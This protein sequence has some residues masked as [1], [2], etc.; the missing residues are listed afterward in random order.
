MTYRLE[1]LMQLNLRTYLICLLTF[2]FAFA[3]IGCSDENPSGV[4]SD[5]T[6]NILRGKVLNVDINNSTV[7]VE[8]LA[9]SHNL[10]DKI[11]GRIGSKISLQVQ[12]GDLSLLSNKKVFVGNLQETFSSTAGK[13]FLLYDVW[14]DEKAERIRVKNV[15]RLLRR[16]TLGMGEAMLRTVGD[17]LPPF[18][19]YDQDG[20]VVT[21]DYFDGSVTVLNFIFS[22]C[23]VAEMC[24]A[25]TIKMKK[26]QELAH[27]IKIPNIRFLSIT[28]DP[29]F[30]SP[31]VLK[32]YARGYN[33]EESNFKVCT[34][35]KPVIDDLTR[36]FGIF[37]E[38]AP[39]Q[40]L[41]HTMRTMI[42]NSKRQIVYQVPGKSWRVEDFLSRLQGG[43]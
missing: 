15:N 30:D 16:D 40:P 31:G 36:Q 39:D 33:L 27:K 35:E 37:R 38:T 25:A 28:L 14:P 42:I 17:N 2:Y 20:E 3:N 22:R 29:A 41:D 5:A 26:L 19:L 12:P 11:P 9:R 24:P 8:I 34:A 43:V 13:I 23:S 21:T 4:R 1:L 7:E 6:E 10:S 32:S 18:A